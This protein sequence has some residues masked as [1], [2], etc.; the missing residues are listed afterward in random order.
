MKSGNR[1]HWLFAVSLALT[2]GAAQA[3]TGQGASHFFEGLS[4]PFG[5]DHLLAMVAVGVWSVSALPLQKAWQGPAAFLLALVASAALG[6][7]GLSVPFLEQAV[8]LS[9][10]VLGGLLALVYKSAPPSAGLAVIVVAALLHGM[11][12]GTEAPASGFGGY[13]MGFMLTTTLLHVGG[14]MF[15]L[16]LQRGS[17]LRRGSVM[18]GLGAMLG[19]AGLYLFGQLT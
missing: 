4:H 11:A 18:T 17:D 7:A 6:A 10:V 13:A 8:A 5:W 14:V 16:A 1:K 19:M 9:V 15:G 2:A 12:H 3:H